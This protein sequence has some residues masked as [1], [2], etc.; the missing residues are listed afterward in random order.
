MSRPDITGNDILLYVAGK[1]SPTRRA[2]VE[3]TLQANS[4]LVSVAFKLASVWNAIR[5]GPVL[6][7]PDF[8]QN[9]GRHFWRKVSG[10][11]GMIC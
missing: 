9:Y 5:P 7:T 1:L 8:N 4:D 11:L 3:L 6:V 2:E 10:P